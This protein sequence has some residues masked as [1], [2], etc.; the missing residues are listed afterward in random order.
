MSARRRNLL[1][2]FQNA[3]HAPSGPSAP[4]PEGPRSEPPR[5]PRAPRAPGVPAEPPWLLAVVALALVFALGFALGRSTGGK[6]EAASDGAAQTTRR[7]A[8]PAPRPVTPAPAPENTEPPRIEESA[9]FDVRNKYTVIVITYD[10]GAAGQDYAWATYRHLQDQ[11]QPVFPPVVSGKNLLVLV[12]A[13]PTS[14]ELENT[15]SAVRAL[16]RDGKKPYEKA[17]RARI[18][19]LITRNTQGN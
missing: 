9:L 12:G 13:A 19:K 2:A 10:N 4:A 3:T 17:Y 1:E 18:D 16:V 11:G 6:V 7:P 14:G 15:E 8:T 5:P